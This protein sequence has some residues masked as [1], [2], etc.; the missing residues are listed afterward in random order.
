MTL[1]DRYVSNLQISRGNEANLDQAMKE[2]DDWN[3]RFSNSGNTQKRTTDTNTTP[4]VG[5]Q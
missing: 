2:I 4:M 3:A 5:E 1:V